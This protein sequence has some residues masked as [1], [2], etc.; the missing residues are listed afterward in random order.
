MTSSCDWPE[1]LQG[2]AESAVRPME[3]PVLQAGPGPAGILSPDAPGAK[4]LEAKLAAREA[5]FARQL[6]AARREASEQGK[7]MAAA[8]SSAW[9][10]QRAAELA[11]AMEALRA[12]RDSYLAQ[13]EKEVVR[14]A[15]AIAE[16]ILQRESQ[17]DPLL[18]SGAVRTALGQLADSTE[19]RLRVPGDQ[20]ELWT[21]L[22]RLMP[23]LQIRPQVV[24]D[25]ELPGCAVVL[26][27]S[28]GTVDL[29][30]RAQLDEIE[31]G[32]FD[33]V[34]TRSEGGPVES[35]GTVAAGRNG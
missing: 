35:A 25:D 6:E 12:S 2:E 34:E 4:A 33:R 26:E 20:R 30:V 7:L 10:Q 3:Y 11:A 18:L 27:S 29:S 17:L 5:V 19:A 28:L 9:R 1:S 16:R 24:A 8:E 15:L 14:L 23:G 21:D 13:V 31:R 32:F 22:V